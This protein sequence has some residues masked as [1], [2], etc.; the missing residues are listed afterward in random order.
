MAVKRAMN[1]GYKMP[2]VKK[3]TSI[4]SGK[5]T[6]THNRGGGQ[7]GSTTSKNY[8]KKQRGQGSRR[9]R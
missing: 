7:G 8:K 6:K 2:S 1:R 5:F 4:G 3:K 9:R